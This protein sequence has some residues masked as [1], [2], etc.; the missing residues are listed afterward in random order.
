MDRKFN[1]LGAGREAQGLGNARRWG[2]VHSFS[3]W[4]SECSI[5]CNATNLKHSRKPPKRQMAVVMGVFDSH[6]T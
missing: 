6:L 4:C 5:R 1:G 3:A 2:P